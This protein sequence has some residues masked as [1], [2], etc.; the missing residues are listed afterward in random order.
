MV[1]VTGSDA[2]PHIDG[3]GRP[4]EYAVKMRRFPQEAL[5]SRMAQGGTLGVGQIDTT[6]DDSTRLAARAGRDGVEVTLEVVPEM[7]HGFQGLAGLFPEATQSL[8]RAGAFV[9]RHIP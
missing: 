9:R 2:D 4:I 6:C 8:E 3:K 5:L 7:I 1:P